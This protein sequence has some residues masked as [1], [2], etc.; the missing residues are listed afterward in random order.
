MM[1]LTVVGL[2]TAMSFLMAQTQLN[3]TKAQSALEL[4]QANYAHSVNQLAEMAAPE[5]IISL[6]AVNHLTVPSSVLQIGEVSLLTPLPMPHFRQ[7]VAILSRAVAS[8]APSSTSLVPATPVVR[9]TSVA[10]SHK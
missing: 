6:G 2:L 4:A 1:M 8:P 3:T 5:R 9:L 10:P 7:R